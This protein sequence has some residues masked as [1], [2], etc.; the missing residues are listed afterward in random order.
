M[1]NAE[2]SSGEIISTP[3]L[4]LSVHSAPFRREMKEMA[5]FFGAGASPRAFVY[6]I[7]NTAILV[8]AAFR[9][10]HCCPTATVAGRNTKA[11]FRVKLVF[12]PIVSGLFEELSG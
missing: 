1:S 2:T 12:A 7:G 9:R 10:R 5:F 6:V 11:S 4:F 3:L 8:R